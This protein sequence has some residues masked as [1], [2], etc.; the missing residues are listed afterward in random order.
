MEEEEKEEERVTTMQ[1]FSLVSTLRIPNLGHTDT[2][3]ISVSARMSPRGKGENESRNSSRGG[4]KVANLRATTKREC[5]RRIVLESERAITAGFRSA[6]VIT[7]TPH[8]NV[9]L[10][11][12]FG[13][14]KPARGS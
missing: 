9:F 13:R 6:R 5:E 11:E 2:N 1:S 10:R 7:S 12:F 3:A 14:N 8:R 4:P